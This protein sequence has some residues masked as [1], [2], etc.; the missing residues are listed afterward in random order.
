MS[1]TSATWTSV[2]VRKPNDRAAVISALFEAGAEGVQELD[3]EI[4]THIRDADQGKVTSAV[5]R[6]DA[7]ATVE[8]GQTP[9]V[10][11]SAEW[12]SR[13]TAH[14]LERLVVTPPWL[15]D[16]FAESERI[17]IDPG[18]AFGTGDHETTRGVLRLLQRVIRPGD[19]V[20]D[21]GPGSAVLG[22]GAAKLGAAR[23]IA[24]ELD[25]DAI[26]NAEENVQRNG[27]ADRVTVIEG[28]AALLLP[29]VAP[30]RVVLANILSSVL[31]ALM[32][33]IADALTPDGVAILSGI[34]TAEKGDIEA[35]AE[36]GGWRIVETDQED[37]WWSA[38][39][40]R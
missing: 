19:T 27:V 9:A 3:D 35:A 11:W 38:S 23:V 37:M 12:R 24:I 36:S 31:T 1:P 20:A 33:V 25:P 40:A 29:L 22:I 28:D 21:L 7:G 4:V 26:G 6:V 39:I 14:R 5:R 18:M 30:V 2:R 16:R 34:L 15:A 32:P 17:I 8:Y 10:D 13:I